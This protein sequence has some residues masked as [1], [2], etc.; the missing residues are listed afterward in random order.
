[1]MCVERLFVTVAVLP[2]CIKTTERRKKEQRL[3]LERQRI[4]RKLVVVKVY[5]VICYLYS[6]LLC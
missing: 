2:V 6:I 1:M 5:V 3:T 4:T